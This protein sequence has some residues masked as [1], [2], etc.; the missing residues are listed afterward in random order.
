MKKASLLLL[1]L[2]AL[3]I[4]GCA[5]GGLV[6]VP[7]S[8]GYITF[9]LKKADFEAMSVGEPTNI[10]VRITHSNGFLIAKDIPVTSESEVVEIKVPAV[11]GY[12]ID[13]VS[14]EEKAV[15]EYNRLLKYDTAQNIVVRPGE[16]TMVELVL[17]PFEIDLT[18]PEEVISGEKFQLTVSNVPDVVGNSMRMRVMFRTAPFSASETETLSDSIW[19]S[20]GGDSFYSGS[21]EFNAPASDVEGNMYVQS[22]IYLDSTFAL[23]NEDLYINYVYWLPDISAG[24]PQISVPLKLPEGGI[25]VGI[26]Y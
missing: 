22:Y 5:V 16:T 18:L 14:Y 6:E 19:L 23:G 24:E 2:I 11:D 4:V 21:G 13:A 26:V 8:E 20:K 12:R 25:G 17:K 7:Q 9:Y 3:L 1:I 15:G 10:R